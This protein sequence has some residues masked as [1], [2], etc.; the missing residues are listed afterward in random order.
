MWGG[1]S[2]FCHVIKSRKVKFDW[3]MLQLR[4]LHYTV[5]MPLQV[6]DEIFVKLGRRVSPRLRIWSCFEAVN[7]P[8]LH[9]TSILDVDE[10][11]LH[12]RMLWMGMWV[13][14]ITQL[15]HCGAGDP[16][17]KIGGKGEPE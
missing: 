1:E 9:L 16:I 12:L 14:H 15:H 13:H 17:G 5:F 6:K 2:F 10:V 4:A 3:S 11:L 7:H 8:T